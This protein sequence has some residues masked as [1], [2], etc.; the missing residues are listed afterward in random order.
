MMNLFKKITGLFGGSLEQTI[1]Q[2]LRDF[3]INQ[4]E[5]MAL[6]LNA[7]IF[8]QMSE[9]QQLTLED[10]RQKIFYR[11]GDQKFHF[12]KTHG[13]EYKGG[14]DLEAFKLS[15]ELMDAG[16]M[17]MTSYP[18]SLLKQD[19]PQGISE[20]EELKAFEW[21]RVSFVVLKEAMDDLLKELEQNRPTDQLFQAQIFA[22]LRNGCFEWRLLLFQLDIQLIFQEDGGLL[23]SVYND[24]PHQPSKGPAH[25]ALYYAQ[26]GPVFDLMVELINK[27][28]LL[29]RAYLSRWEVSAAKS[30]M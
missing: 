12:G 19:K 2:N 23:C 3:D 1:E 20:A 27:T 24:I 21:L 7:N 6:S 30:S 13:S 16:L 26:R 22:G 29:S 25:R 14:A 10:S 18:T 15:L 28:S 11:L 4:L 9:N 8:H 5:W 17:W